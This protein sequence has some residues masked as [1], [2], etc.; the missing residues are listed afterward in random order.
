M[1]G[2]LLLLALTPCGAH[3][4]RHLSQ[5]AIAPIDGNPRRTAQQ[6]LGPEVFLLFISITELLTVRS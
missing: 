2:S 4:G 3:L 6:H 5:S 1:Q